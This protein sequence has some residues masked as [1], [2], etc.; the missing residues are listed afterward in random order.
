M[1][2]ALVKHKAALDAAPSLSHTAPSI[3]ASP[4]SPPA[5]S[6]ANAGHLG[7]GSASLAGH[8]RA[9]VSPIHHGG[10]HEQDGKKQWQKVIE[11]LQP[12]E[13]W[14]WG[15]QRCLLGSVPSLVLG[16]NQGW[17]TKGWDGMG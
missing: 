10:R 12:W 11:K 17:E 14:G 9:Q 8:I 4:S 16:Q 5:L 13:R 3:T 15:E 1:F 7:K 6:C 2:A